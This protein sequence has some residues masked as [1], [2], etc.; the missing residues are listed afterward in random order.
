MKFSFLIS[1]PYFSSTFNQ[2]HLKSD[3]FNMPLTTKRN[4]DTYFCLLKMGLKLNMI[5][6]LSK[7]IAFT[8]ITAFLS[9]VGSTEK[10]ITYF[11][12]KIINPK[13]NHVILYDNEIVLDTFYLDRND[14]FLGEI[15]ALNE[16]LYYFKHGNEHQYIYLEPTD[17]LLLRL[18]TWDFD[19]SLVFSGKGAQRNNLLIDCFLDSE[20]QDK[21]FYKFYDLTPEE[22]RK[23]VD[24]LEEIK[25]AT[26]DEFDKNNP[27]ESDNYKEILKIAL[28]YPLYAKVENYPMAHSAMSKQDNDRTEV[29]S[30]FYPHRDKIAIDKDSIMYFYAYRDFVLSHLYNKV[31]TAGHKLESDEFTVSLLKTIANE[32]RNEYTRNA[33]LRQTMI[34]HFYRKSS[35]NV[36][37]EAFHTYLQL[38]TND[39]DKRLIKALLNDSRKLHKGKKIYN[40]KI[41]D[42]NK[43]DRAI[44]S[45]IKGKNA[46]VYFWNSDFVS[47][48]YIAARVKYLSKEFPDVKF[49]GVKIDGKGKDRI[50]QLDIKS[51]Y[52]IGPDSKANQFLTSKMPRTLLIDKKGVITNGYAALSSRNIH[53]QIGNLV[54]N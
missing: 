20:K 7:L 35:C 32:L 42:Y 18:N 33:I 52:Y 53:E 54:K 49:V 24:S 23:K 37:N 41:K 29:N 31:N 21:L 16:G 51:Q 44:K 11:G 12:G 30:S 5:E 38:S 15:P 39:S 50:K 1:I 8:T 4:I 27:E 22:F 10:N 19:E 14:V 45:I 3:R 43:T 36:N 13:S 40:F 28:T 25:L 9:C 47:K 48:E 26:Y 2:T 46:V 6:R 17:S 34:G